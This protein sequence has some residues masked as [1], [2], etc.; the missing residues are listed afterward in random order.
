MA[1]GIQ[2]GD[3]EPITAINVTPLVDVVLVLLVIFMVTTEVI[4]EEERPKALAVQLPASAS[5]EEMLSQGL[6]PLT[7]DRQGK[8]YL[9]QDET[10]YAVLSLR[11]AELKERKITPQALLSADERVDHGTVV[12]LMDFLKGQNVSEIAINTKKQAIE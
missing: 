11:I 1:G 3:D 4:H 5:A 7:I 12:T 10:T 6:L 9:G 2:D 8:L